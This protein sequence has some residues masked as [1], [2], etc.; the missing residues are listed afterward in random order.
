MKHNCDKIV[1]ITCLN[2]L[3][4]IWRCRD[5]LESP[6]ALIVAEA[7]DLINSSMAAKSDLEGGREMKVLTDWNWFFT[8]GEKGR[9]LYDVHSG[10]GGGGTPKGDEVY[11]GGWVNSVNSILL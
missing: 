9:Y 6:R 8:D 4:N 7:S 5:R 2:T 11:D 1:N 3:L 10:R